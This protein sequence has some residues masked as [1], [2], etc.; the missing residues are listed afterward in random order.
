MINNILLCIFTT[1]FAIQAQAQTIKTKVV[2]M[3]STAGGVAAAIQASRSG[4]KTLLVTP[5][6]TLSPSLDTADIAYLQRIQNHYA[7]KK[8]KKS[9]V[10][11]SVISKD[12]TP[13]QSAM[14]IKSIADTVK[15]LTVQTGTTI[16]SIK[17]AGKGWKI[18]L[19]NGQKVRADV[20]ID[21]TADFVVAKM[22]KV[23]AA[24]TLISLNELSLNNTYANKLF[25]TSVGVGLYSGG[26]QSRNY[27][28]P[29]GTLLPAGT[30]NFIIVPV[31][32]GAFQPIALSAGQAAGAS[33][34]YCAFFN[35]T[36]KSLNVR[37]VQGELLAFESYIIPFTD[38]AFTDRH[39]LALQHIGA[40]GLL[41][42]K[43]IAEGTETTI[44]FDTAGT[45]SSEELRLP[46][47]E[48]YSRSQLWFGDT[49]LEKLTVKDAIDL[50]MFTATRGEELRSEIEKGWQSSLRF[51]S[52]Y[53]PGRAINRR[54]FAVLVDRFLKPFSRRVDVTGRLL[55]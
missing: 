16:Q 17:K 28:V 47:K 53:D 50:I 55:N 2:V 10:K 25:R 11:D 5:D 4:V 9:T 27:I 36:T 23:E 30:E 21:A 6:K 20:V 12:V 35:T 42:G 49:T 18:R 13:Q 46:M 51:T 31:Q 26:G 44:Q 39:A 37:V 33:A 41:K 8:I 54:E 7:Y 40:T 19:Q 38:I 15:N 34:A 24:K 3:G 52:K 29:I 43:T 14:L 22:L 32:N 1:L 45:L 48:Y